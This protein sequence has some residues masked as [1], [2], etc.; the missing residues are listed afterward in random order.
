MGVTINTPNGW[1]LI[2]NAVLGR[3][4]F[5]AEGFT[6]D[7]L[8]LLPETAEVARCDVVPPLGKGWHLVGFVPRKVTQVV[9]ATRR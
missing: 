3:P 8:F 5:E 7:G 4:P 2:G 9:R 1:G 6:A